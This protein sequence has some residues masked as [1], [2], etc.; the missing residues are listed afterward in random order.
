MMA[1]F[2]LGADKI[3]IK[4][5]ENIAEAWGLVGKYSDSKKLL[6]DAKKKKIAYIL[7][8]DPQAIE[9]EI[10]NELEKMNVKIINFDDRKRLE[11]LIK[12]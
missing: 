3:R 1:I 10:R 7:V 8:I 4:Q 12:I 6:E 9:D 5:M 11:G 2:T